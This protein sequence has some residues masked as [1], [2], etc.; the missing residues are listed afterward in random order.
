VSKYVT[1]T[2]T[3]EDIDAAEP[4]SPTDCP[5]ALALRRTGYPKARVPRADRW[6]PMGGQ[7]TYWLPLTRRA[8]T[9]I[10]LFDYAP[11]LVQPATFRLPLP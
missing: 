9:F 5:I 4:C 11:E 8:G 10:R 7:T 2:V 3:Q 1:V 6:Q